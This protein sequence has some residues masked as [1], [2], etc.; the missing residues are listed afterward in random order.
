[1][2]PIFIQLR[3]VIKI[4]KWVIRYKSNNQDPLLKNKRKLCSPE[5]INIAI[6]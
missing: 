4:V 5:M 3:V 1:M 6:I 2:E